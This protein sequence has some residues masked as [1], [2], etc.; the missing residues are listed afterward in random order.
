MKNIRNIL[1][2]VLALGVSSIIIVQA[3]NEAGEH[4]L[5]MPDDIEWQTG[6]PFL[7]PGAEFVILAGDPEAGAFILRLKLPA[8]YEIPAHQHSA[9]KYLT[10]ISGTLH[11]G[12]GDELDTSQGMSL[13]AGGFVVVPAGH[14]HYEWV[15]EETILQAHMTETF[16]IAYANPE[17]DP[18]IE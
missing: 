6:L 17:H 16:D 5:V 7:A 10:V 9:V 8:G 11:L 2:T 3:Q 4:I 14:N 13:P 12:M 1:M 15:E 18:R